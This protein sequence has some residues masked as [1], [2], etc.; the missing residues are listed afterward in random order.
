MAKVDGLKNKI[1][2]RDTRICD[3]IKIEV[4]DG[5]GAGKAVKLEKYGGSH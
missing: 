5:C 4:K 2:T 1:A 3:D